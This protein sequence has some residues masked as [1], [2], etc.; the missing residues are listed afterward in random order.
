MVGL[1]CYRIGETGQ[2]GDVK[3]VVKSAILE[4]GYRHL[5]T[6][7][8][9]DNE[10]VIGEAMQEC[11]AAGVPREDLYITTKLW[12]NMAPGE[13]DVFSAGFDYSDIE[14]SCRESMRRLRV[15]Y[16]DL[17]LIHWMILP[18]DFES[19]D[20][21]VIGPPFHVVWQ[22]MEQLVKKGLVKSIGVSN[23]TI[24]MMINLLAGCEIKPAINQIEVHPYRNCSDVLRF[25]NKWG[26]TL[27][28]YCPIGGEGGWGAGG[29]GGNALNDPVIA[30]IAA[31]KGKSPA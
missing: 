5:D 30:E 12:N 31:A 28:A 6:A 23:C 1:G 19:E 25:H 4:H 27:E 26:I 10:E 8:V 17:Y 14:A 9:Y 16:L 13:G 18:I 21:R 22:Q 7:R 2:G 20:W 24:P 15:E 29:V 11:V 3:S